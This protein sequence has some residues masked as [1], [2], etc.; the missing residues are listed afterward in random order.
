VSKTFVTTNVACRGIIPDSPLAATV[1]LSASPCVTASFEARYLPIETPISPSFVS[2]R[3]EGPTILASIGELFRR[4]GSMPLS[5]T[6][7]PVAF[8][9]VVTTAC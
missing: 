9:S 8:V 7:D 1:R 2:N 3:C 6:S 5:I 4:A